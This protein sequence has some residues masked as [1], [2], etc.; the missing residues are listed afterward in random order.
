MDQ[1]PKPGIRETAILR[2]DG[3]IEIN[4][5]VLWSDDTMAHGSEVVT[6]SSPK[7]Q[8]VLDR[9]PNLKIDEP[10]KILIPLPEQEENQNPAG[11]TIRPKLEG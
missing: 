9:H 3:S 7:Y 10:D 6:P 5:M 2:A 8:E 1:T 4:H 11:F